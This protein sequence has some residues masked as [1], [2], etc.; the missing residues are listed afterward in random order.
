[1]GSPSVENPHGTDIAG[2]PA[3]IA[4]VQPFISGHWEGFLDGDF[5]TRDANGLGDLGVSFDMLVWGARARTR[6]QAADAEQRE[7]DRE[8]GEV[9]PH[10]HREYSGQGKLEKQDG[11]TCEKECCRESS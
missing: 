5:R 9:V 7:P 1:M 10:Q 8:A 2:K 3:R 4:V 11:E 6:E